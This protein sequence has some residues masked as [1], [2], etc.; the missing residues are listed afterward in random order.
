MNEQEILD[1]AKRAAM[2]V[3]ELD[4]PYDALL[5]RRDRKR[6]NQ[7]ITAG[8]VGIAVFVAAVWILTTSGQFDRTQTPATTGPTITT[9]PPAPPSKR[10]SRSVAGVPFSLTV[11]DRQWTAGPITRLADGSGGFREGDLLIS[12]SIK[13]PQGAE[14]VI[15]WTAFPDG[16][17]ADP[18][19]NLVSSPVGPS[20][21]DLA[22]A[23][24]AAPGTELVGGPS[25]VT[26]GGYPA[27]HVMLTVREDSSCEPG[28][29]YTW[30]SECWGPCWMKTKRD[31]TIEVWIVDVVGTRLFI[32]AETTPQADSDLKQEI[33]QIIGSIRFGDTPTT[34]PGAPQ[35]DYVLDLNTGAMTPLPEAIIRSLGGSVLSGR[36][37]VSP[38]GSLLAYV[39]LGDEGTPQIFISGRSPGESPGVAGTE[40]RQATNERTGAT[41]P[42]WSPGG[43]LIAYEGGGNHPAAGAGHLFVLNVATGESTPLDLFGGEPQFTPDGSSL[44]YTTPRSNVA[45]VWTR[46]VVGGKSTFLIG[47]GG[48]LLDAG[49]ASLSP[50][51]SLVTFLGRWIHGPGPRRWLANADGTDMRQLPTGCTSSPAG[52]W[53][54][55]GSRIVCSEGNSILV[56]EI[57]TED[58]SSVAEGRA[59]IWLDDHTLLVEV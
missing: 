46:P 5:R 30:R 7:R 39:G 18:C 25:D 13:G 12:K 49:N 37:A 35:V 59:S 24:A 34:F 53:S 4:Q 21:A 28:F 16:D 19:S 1:R 3:D 11:P 32:E 44:V 10:L 54:P 9:G 2:S 26:V 55:D 8:V 56:V 50:D 6:R 36:Y 42:A 23:V 48:G 15:F 27:K 47:P 58:V 40:V 29:F 14:A 57:A 51:G 38:D 43:E 45:E 33:Q 22:A 31:D 17:H 20:A 41:S 52:T